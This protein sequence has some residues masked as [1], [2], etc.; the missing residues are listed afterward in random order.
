MGRYVLRRLLQ[1]VPVFLGTTFLIYFLMFAVP[2]DPLDNL[3]GGR[4]ENPAYLEY[5]TSQFNLDDPFFVQYAKY[6]MGIFTGDLGTTFSGQA[7]TEIFAER[8]PVTVQ[9]A[10]TALVIEILI[11]VSLGVWAALRR[12]GVIDSLA[13]GGTLVVIS[14]PVFVLAYVAQWV[15]G[16][17]LG[18]LPASGIAD[19]WP[20]SYLLPAT[21]LALLSLAYV[22]RLTRQSLLETVNQD[23][24]STAR[25]KGLP[26]RRIIRE[27]GLRNSLIPVVTFLG[28]DLAALMGGAVVVEGIFNVPG[29][30][31]QLYSS[32]RLGEAVVVVGTVTALVIAYL[33]MNLLVDVLYAVL[34]PRIRYD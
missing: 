26:A 24:F 29:I 21:V 5:L 10:L 30:G 34:D 20:V 18:W 2:G 4:Q 7:V 33:L 3:A 11:G 13:L 19:G 6:L 31:Q 17:K 9:L 28:A 1:V 23:F 25:A 15:I 16:V 8:W 27:Y 12:G 22:L 14:I 32:I